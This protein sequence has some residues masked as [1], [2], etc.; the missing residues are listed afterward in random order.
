MEELATASHNEVEITRRQLQSSGVA[1]M[2]NEPSVGRVEGML[3]GTL[4]PTPPVAPIN[5]GVGASRRHATAADSA[6]E[7]GTAEEELGSTNGS[8]GIAGAAGHVEPLTSS[9]ETGAQNSPPNAPPA[10]RN[11]R[12]GPTLGARRQRYVDTTAPPAGQPAQHVYYPQTDGALPGSPWYLDLGS[13]P[14]PADE[15]HELADDSNPDVVRDCESSTAMKIDG[16]NTFYV[17]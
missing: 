7:G 3:E 10:A 15:S 1:R 16:A 9:N 2:Q 12:D 4:Q 17:E 11:L 14:Q 8:T 6:P 13:G 5:S